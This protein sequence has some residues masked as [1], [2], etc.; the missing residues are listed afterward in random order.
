MGYVVR[1]I[2]HYGLL[3]IVEIPDGGD[4][5]PIELIE[6]GMIKRFFRSR[7]KLNSPGLIHHIT[8]RAAGKEPL[9]LEKDDYMAMLVLM[10]V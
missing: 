10:S 8:Q 2:Y 6:K 1:L 7:R 3:A 4:M 9:F 5:D